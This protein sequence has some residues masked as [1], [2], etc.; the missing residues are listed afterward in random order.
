MI[1]PVFTLLS[2]DALVGQKIGAGAACRCYPA[3]DA[4]EGV[5]RPY[6]TW[7]IVG[8]EAHRILSGVPSSDRFVVTVDIWSDDEPSLRAAAEPVRYVLENAGDIIRYNDCGRDPD[9]GRYRYSFDWEYIARRGLYPPDVITV[10][11]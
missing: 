6:V 3:G 10:G 8:G 9:T 2:S 7:L 5:A 4:P 11:D 1:P